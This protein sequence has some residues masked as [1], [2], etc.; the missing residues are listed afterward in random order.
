MN[1]YDDGNPSLDKVLLNARRVDS[2]A[3]LGK[4]NI[5][6]VPGSYDESRAYSLAQGMSEKELGPYVKQGPVSNAKFPPLKKAKISPRNAGSAQAAAEILDATQMRQPQAVTASS[7]PTQIRQSLPSAARAPGAI[8][9]NSITSDMALSGQHIPADVQT[10]AYR[11]PAQLPAVSTQSRAGAAFGSVDAP[12]EKPF[13]VDPQG[14]ASQQYRK[15]R[16]NPISSPEGQAWNAERN[17][18]VMGGGTPPVPPPSGGGGIPPQKPGIGATIKSY[19][20]AGANTAKGIMSSG[21]NAAREIVNSGAGKGTAIFTLANTAMDVRSTPTEQ[22]RERF[23]LGPDRNPTFAG[24]V[25]VRTLG[26]ASELGANL[27]VVG[28]IIKEGLYRDQNDGQG[29]EDAVKGGTA[30]LAGLGLGAGAAKLASKLPGKYGKIASVL[31]GAAGYGMGSGGANFL[32]EKG[33]KFIDKE[34]SPNGA[35]RDQGQQPEQIDQSGSGYMIDSAGNRQ[36]YNPATQ[37]FEGADVG[38]KGGGTFNVMDGSAQQ[39]QDRL[40]RLDAAFAKYQAAGDLEGMR[41]VGDPANKEHQIA[42][43]AAQRV[44]RDAGPNVKM[45]GGEG[46]NSSSDLF[47]EAVQSA[48]NIK[49][50]KRRAEVLGRLSEQQQGASLNRSKDRLTSSESDLRQQEMALDIASKKRVSGL[51]DNLQNARTPEERKSAES[52]LMAAQGKSVSDKYMQVDVP[53]EKLDALGQPVMQRMVINPETQEVFDPRGQ[54]A[55]NI[56]S[57][58][59]PPQAGLKYAGKDAKTGQIVWEDAKGNRVIDDGK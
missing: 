14:N 44:A 46:L 6:Y 38:K 42:I 49:N 23:G 36:D 11:Q 4:K 30:D 3:D 53:T 41:R 51:F 57:N 10:G 52:A 24:D 47:S 9:T 18:G 50:P 1:Y 5:P 48:G 22:Y 26:A 17:A 29:L 8:P 27:P 16:A 28:P 32:M 25:G 55:S 58:P 39:Q 19:G 20:G 2:A 45:I 35:P 59:K 33:S 12:P 15:P 31:A 54:N 7:S 43:G 37:R 40:G 56:T 13:Y 21:T 34:M